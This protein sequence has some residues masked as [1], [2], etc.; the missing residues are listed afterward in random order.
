MKPFK[1]PLESLRVL[2]QQKENIAQQLYANALTVCRRAE[3]QLQAAV[4]ELTEGWESFNRDMAQGV[5]AGKITGTRTWWMV[6]EIRRNEC[7]AALDEAHRTASAA[8]Q[9]MLAAVRDREALDRFY[10]K[11]RLAYNRESQREEQKNFDEM[12]VQSGGMNSRLQLA[13][14]EN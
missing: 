13:G 1:F 7:K 12:A 2:R 6:L 10:E 14:C 9:A 4:T 3:T 5:A 11:S 8:F